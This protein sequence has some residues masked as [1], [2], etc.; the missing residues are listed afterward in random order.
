M[1]PTKLTTFRITTAL[2]NAW[3]HGRE[4]MVYAVDWL[5]TA[6]EWHLPVEV[7]AMLNYILFGLQQPKEPHKENPSVTKI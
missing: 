6:L 7:D 2:E 1:T 3:E 4:R 5:A